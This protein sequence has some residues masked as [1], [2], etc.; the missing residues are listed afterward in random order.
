MVCRTHFVYHLNLLFFFFSLKK[1]R[2][3]EGDPERGPERGPEGGSRRGVQVL[4]TP[5]S[6]CWLLVYNIN[7]K[8]SLLFLLHVV[9]SGNFSRGVLTSS[10]SPLTNPR[11]LRMMICS[12][13]MHEFSFKV[14][15]PIANYC[16]V[17]SG[18]LM[19]FS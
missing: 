11:S 2:G 18:D 14:D 10:P 3:P 5:H 6:Y 7:M 9:F 12:A 17:K 8:N 4:S 15:I 1:L 16:F 19:E 13:P